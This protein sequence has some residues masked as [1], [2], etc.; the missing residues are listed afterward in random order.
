MPTKMSAEEA[1]MI[2]QIAELA[3]LW[4]NKEGGK[5]KTGAPLDAVKICWIA[6][7]RKFKELDEWARKVN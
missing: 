1:E 3:A 7:Y 5:E 6:A 4:Y 2:E